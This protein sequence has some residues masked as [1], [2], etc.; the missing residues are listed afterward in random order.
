ML[1]KGGRKTTLLIWV[2]PGRKLWNKRK[3]TVTVPHTKQPLFDPISKAQLQPGV[4]VRPVV[5]D[6]TWLIQKHRDMIEDFVDL[7]THE[8]QYMEEWDAFMAKRKLASDHYLGREILLFLR[9]K[10]SWLVASK[11]R[12][13]EFAKHMSSLVARGLLDDGLLVDILSYVHE[14]R[15]QKGVRG[16]ASLN[17]PPE[18]PPRK[19]AGGCGACGLPV[20]AA[21]QLFCYGEV[22]LRM[23]NNPV[24]SLCEPTLT[25]SAMQ[26]CSHRLYHDDCMGGVSQVS[27]SQHPWICDMCQGRA[28][29]TSPTL[30]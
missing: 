9:A 8:K 10:G 23:L 22:S 28:S 16:A 29:L 15:T 18:K 24:L 5:H 13:L 20:M 27:V 7:S 11:G 21:M 30:I 17:G 3:R 14:A 6:D 4:E 2:Q 12:I 26:A 25:H 1:N 19:S